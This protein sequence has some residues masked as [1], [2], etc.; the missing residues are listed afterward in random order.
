LAV[1]LAGITIAGNRWKGGRDLAFRRTEGLA[2]E[3]GVV[4][5]NYDRVLEAPLASLSRLMT[6]SGDYSSPEDALQ[7]AKL[8]GSVDSH[9]VAPTWRKWVG[10]KLAGAWKKAYTLLSEANHIRIVGYSLPRSDA[11]MRYL[12]CAAA[13]KS[14]HLKRIDIIDHSPSV[15]NHYA[16]VIRYTKA[17]FL[18]LGVDEYLG[19]LGSRCLAYESKEGDR[20]VSPSGELEAHHEDLMIKK[21]SYL[22]S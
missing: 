19:R 22:H 3:Y 18:C 8:H 16:S 13:Q 12:L 9:V 5:L 20:L 15:K 14:E 21:G 11:Y 4:T 7:I 17:R 10:D 6:C 2:T 1:C